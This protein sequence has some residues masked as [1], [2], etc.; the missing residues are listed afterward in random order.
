MGGQCPMIVKEP[1][2]PVSY[3]V[4]MFSTVTDSWMDTINLML[5][6]SAWESMERRERISPHSKFRVVRRVTTDTVLTS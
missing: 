6:S 3:V 2:E 5:E 4:Q 1:P